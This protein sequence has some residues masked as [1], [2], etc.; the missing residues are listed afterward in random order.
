M[1]THLHPVL[2]AGD[3][4]SQLLVVL[5]QLGIIIAIAR[6]FAMAFRRIGQP[7][8]VGE[9][10]AGL[11][12][13]PSFLGRLEAAGWLP[14]ISSYIFDPAVAPI[15]GIMSQLGLILLLF[16]V[17]LEFDFGH[18]R[19][20]GRSAIS[21]SITGIA[22]PLLLGMGLGHFLHGRLPETIDQLGFVLF[23]GV[24]MSITALPIL[25][26]MMVEMKI[27]RTRVG[28]VTITSAAVDDALGW[29][30]LAAVSALVQSRFNILHSAG[31]IGLT[32]LFGAGMILLV[33]P[34]M[35]WWIARTLARGSDNLTLNALA[36]VL[37]TLFVCSIATSLIGIFSIFGAFVLG[38]VLSDQ[39][40]F[41][42]AVGRSLSGFVTVFFLPIF[43]T[44]TGL[45]TDIGTLHSLEMWLFAAAVL[46]VACL[47]KFGGCTLAA[48]LSG[49]SLRESTCIGVMMNTRA[50]MELVVI[51]VG[52]DLGVIPQ[53]VF[54]ML[55]IM[56][57]VTT[58][59]TTPILQRAMWGTEL[60][61]GFIRSGFARGL[62]GPAAENLIAE[63]P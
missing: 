1:T 56:A 53:S 36:V 20:R 24:A 8:V 22:A 28:A 33:R 48:R 40:E 45:R 29:I 55:V 11:V 47:A 10:C 7:A 41:R 61:A 6:I 26:R 63:T 59:M 25:G 52:F 4:E 34:L 27:S 14:Q 58:L 50:L 32:I 3:V 17:G 51:N 46:A 62:R 42:R 31:M 18:L 9:I 13:G 12:L 23:M 2:A 15:F 39:H 5:V 35:K 38:A 37:I 16:L 57:L 54:C 43:F 49:F 44:Y 19:S 30:L 21:I 60:E